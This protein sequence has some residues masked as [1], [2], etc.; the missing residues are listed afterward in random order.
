MGAIER[1]SDRSSPSLNKTVHSADR[2][3]V[4]R[5]RED[6]SVR[7][8]CRNSVGAID[9]K[10]VIR[11]AHRDAIGMSKT[12][13]VSSAGRNAGDAGGYYVVGATGVDACGVS[14]DHRVD[15]VM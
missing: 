5:D 7:A 11:A 13:R 9:G 2:D 4:W 15:L 8:G 3:R 12:T 14:Y 6:Y 10:N 1:G